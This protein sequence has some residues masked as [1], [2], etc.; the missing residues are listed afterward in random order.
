MPERPGAGAAA[1]RSRAIEARS[2]GDRRA[3]VTSEAIAPSGAAALQA[4]APGRPRSY[5]TLARYV[6]RHP[7]GA[8]G[9]ALV[10][11][12]VVMAVFA[13]L[14][15]PYN[16]AKS[17]DIPLL[18]PSSKHL[19]GTTAT[20]QD[21]LSRVI[22]G[23]QIS[24]A[25]GFSVMVVNIAVGTTLGLLAGYFQG[26]ADYIIQRSGELW[27]A[28]PQ[29]IALLLIVSILGPPATSGGNLL[30]IAWDLRNLVFAFSLGA[31]FGGSRVVRAATL[32]LKHQDFVLA[33]RALG[34]G[35]LR[36]IRAHLFPNV[37]PYV[38]VQATAILGTVILG[39]AALSF[40]GIGVAPGTPSW[41]QDLSGKNRSY[42]IDAP[43]IAL[44][45]GIA[46]SLTV[47][48][49]NLFGDALR[50]ILDPRLRG[51]T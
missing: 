51:R 1:A 26:A 38:I 47:L 7:L 34:A 3:A 12:F 14:L 30:T 15:T 42:F 31:V 36:I 32:T 21:V 37:F 33:A 48:G 46:I 49:F 41:G 9:A 22:Q 25:I 40:L 29:L 8:F 20:G 6:R 10:L 13:P 43:W 4:I 11:L 19:L 17:V 28:F 35:D 5:R 16:A 2:R 45:P 39:E 44:A 24:L 18:A 50:D 23:S 27:T